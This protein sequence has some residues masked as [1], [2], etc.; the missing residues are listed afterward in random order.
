MSQP[1]LEDDRVIFFS[2]GKMNNTKAKHEGHVEAH[3]WMPPLK[4]LARVRE[5]ELV[6]SMQYSTISISIK[7][8]SLPTYI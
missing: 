2:S 5:M 8:S 3:I 7:V 4:I 1:T 6:Y